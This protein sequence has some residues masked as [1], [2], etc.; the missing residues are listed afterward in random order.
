MRRPRAR[1]RGRTRS[2]AARRSRR[3]P[4]SSAPRLRRAALRRAARASSP[5]KAIVPSRRWRAIASGPS[6]GRCRARVC[7]RRSAVRWCTRRLAAFW[8][9]V[10]DHAA[11]LA[12]PAAARAAQIAAAVAGALAELPRPRWRGL[13]PVVSAG[14]AAR[15]AA[16]LDAWLALEHARPPVRGPANRGVGDAGAW[17]HRVAHAPRPGRHGGNRRPAILDYKTG[18]VEQPAQWF[19]ERPRA[20]Q[21]GLYTLA[22]RAAHPAL[23][24]AWSLTRK[25]APVAAAACGLCRRRPPTGPASRLV[26]HGRAL[27]GLARAR[28][29]VAGRL[30]ALADEIAQRPCGGRAAQAPSP[31]RNCGLHAVCRI[32]SVRQIQDGDGDD[33]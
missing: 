25:L 11:L 8:S 5:R 10:P 13:P 22:Q 32:Q 16:L 18:R 28:G 12:L 4:T 15:L 3:S 29:V 30:G 2:R 26:A 27:P 19:D 21:L 17:R 14:E 9:A 23:P 33:E 24:C 7:R 6:P 31:C 20:S 1:R